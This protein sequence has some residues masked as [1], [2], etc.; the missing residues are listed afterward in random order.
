MVPPP[1]RMVS[2]SG[3]VHVV[4]DEAALKSLALQTPNLILGRR[5][6]LRELV[7]LENTKALQ[8]LPLH[9]KHWQLLER[10]VWLRRVDN[11]ALLPIVGGDGDFYVRNYVGPDHREDSR[12]F[13]GK[14]LQHFI[15]HGWGWSTTKTDEYR[16]R[17]M[18]TRWRR[19]E[20]GFVPADLEAHSLL[21]IQSGP[22][23]TVG[24]QPHMHP[25]NRCKT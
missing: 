4:R 11:G 6:V 24:F 20:I 10:M 21:Y 5:N 25:K 19:C 3:V 9:R 22:F 17:G 16:Q 7:D 12:L 23:S 2:P 18:A 14:R 15:K 1:W 13:D 8:Q